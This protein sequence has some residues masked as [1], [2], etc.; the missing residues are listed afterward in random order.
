[1]NLYQQALPHFQ[2][3]IQRAHSAPL[4]S[5]CTLREQKQKVNYRALHLGHEI[6]RATQELTQKCKTMRKSVRKSTKSH[7]NKNLRGAFS[8][9]EPKPATALSS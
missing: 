9:K 7:S 6:H 5:S 2:Q 1:L 4:P 8:P 3:A